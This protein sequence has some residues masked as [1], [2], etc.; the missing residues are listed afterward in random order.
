MKTDVATE[1][2]P[3]LIHHYRTVTQ[4]LSNYD[5]SNC[6]HHTYHSTAIEG[7]SL[8][9][10]QT[11]SVLAEYGLRPDISTHDQLLAV[12]HDKALD[13]VLLM[14]AQREPINRYAIQQL[15]ST[16]MQQTGGL[17]YSLLSS[18]DTRKGDLRIDSAMAG[19]RLLLDAHKLPAALD[20]LLKEVNSAMFRLKTPRQLYDLSFSA[21]FQL[22]TLHPFGTEN[23]LVARLLM[24]YVQAYHQLPISLVFADNRTL[25]LKSLDD[26]WRQKTS[27]PVINFMHS[28]LRCLLQREIGNLT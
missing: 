17:I 26:S 22:L 24:N 27:L 19:R 13:Q 11:Q 5:R 10:D 18:F 14:A 20:T 25:Y 3:Q 16:V 28:Q 15:A 6:I 12:D 23:G 2:L 7:S 9:L 8:T 1:T 21:H 4:G